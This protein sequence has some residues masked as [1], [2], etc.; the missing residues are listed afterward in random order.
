MPTHSIALHNFEGKLR[1]YIPTSEADALVKA[2]DAEWRCLHCARRSHRGRC[3]G[4]KE[5]E[6]AL[7]LRGPERSK[8]DSRATLTF[9]DSQANVGITKGKYGA[10][11]NAKRVQA[12]RNK[13][14]AWPFIGDTRAV[15][16]WARP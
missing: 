15:R 5:H 8:S 12:A 14:A 13:V 10:R 7:Q 11:P 1:R 16:V 3:V 9:R 6:M 2:G 4:R